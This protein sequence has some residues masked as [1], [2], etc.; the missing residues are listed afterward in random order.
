MKTRTC[1][2]L[3]LLVAMVR[4]DTTPADDPTTA[5]SVLRFETIEAAAGFA[6][7]TPGTAVIRTQQVWRELWN[8][9][10]SITSADG[11]KTPP[12]AIDFNRTMVIGVAWGRRPSGCSNSV[13]AIQTIIQRA[14]EIIV[15]IGPL[16]ELGPCDA[17]VY[18]VQM[19]VVNQSDLP[20]IFEGIV[21]SLVR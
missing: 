7:P 3:L 11:V 21:P 13:E 15:L 9:T 14:G 4:C 8:T 19:V 2:S 12:P 10:W 1:L 17:I 16:P 20:V 18:P 6:V 5:P